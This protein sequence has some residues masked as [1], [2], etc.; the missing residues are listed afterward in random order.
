MEVDETYMGGKY[1]NMHRSKK[2]RMMGAGTQDKIPVVAIKE[3]GGSKIRAKVTRPVSSITLQRMVE[4]AV[5][6]GSTVYTD[7][8]RG[9]MGLGKKNYRHEAVNHSV[10][11]YVREKAHVNGVESFWAALNRGYYGTYH[12]MSEKHL[13]RYVTEFAGRHNAREMDTEADPRSGRYPA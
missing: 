4:E 1:G 8:N 5:K 7:Q 10:G 9:Y 6:E 12:H 11:E 13:D 3:R 2:P